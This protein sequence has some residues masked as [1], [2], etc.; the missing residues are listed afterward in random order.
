MFKYDSTGISASFSGIITTST[1]FGN[2]SWGR[3]DLH[4]RNGENTF[5]AY[6][7]SGFVGI[8]TSAIVQRLNSL[9]ASD[10]T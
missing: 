4:S 3:V 1:Y 9:K 8:K 10:Y 5:D 7:N 2:Y 6:G